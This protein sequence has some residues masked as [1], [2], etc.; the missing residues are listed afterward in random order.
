MMT[1]SDVKKLIAKEIARAGTMTALAREWG[2]SVVT[3]SDIMAGRRGPGPK[4]L[5]NL[6]MIRTVQF[7]KG[8]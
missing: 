7:V 6:G 2:V 5:R 4:V 1:E 8:S 3:I